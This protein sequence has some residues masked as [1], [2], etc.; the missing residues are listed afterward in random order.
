M[1][2]L[3]LMIDV[4]KTMKEK[5]VLQGTFRAEGTK[6]QIRIFNLTNEFAKNLKS[7]ET[8]VKLNTLLDHD[9]K[10][11]KHE[12]YT[13]FNVQ[14]S[15]GH[16]HG[17]MFHGCRGH[18]HHQ[19]HGHFGHDHGMK[20]SGLKD[21]L[22]RLSFVLNI[23]NQLKITEQE[24][25][26]MLLT[27]NMSEFPEEMKRVF[28]EKMNSQH[29]M[30]EQ[31]EHHHRMMKE[32]ISLENSSLEFII[33]INPNNEVEQVLI[34]LEGQKGAEK[35]EIQAMSLRAELNLAW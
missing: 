33:R 9:G 20:H 22:N 13:E 16:G 8:K 21:K 18:W 14:D 32:F 31:H 26:S 3:K 34:D 23:L 29:E 35:E 11:V 25:K 15:H 17:H 19:G 6:N 2:K 7:G 27:L 12:S 4:V 28:Q 24:D 10:Q 5:E 30:P 1:N